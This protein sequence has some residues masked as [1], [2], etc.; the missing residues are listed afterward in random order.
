M[1]TPLQ[2]FLPGKSQ[3]Q[4]R[5]VGYINGVAKELDTT[6]WL[7]NNRIS[8][9]SHYPGESVVKNRPANAGDTGLIPVLGRCS[10]EGN[11]TVHRILLPEESH[12]Q[13]SLVGY[14]S[15]GCTRVGHDWETKNNDCIG[16]LYLIYSWYILILCLE[17]SLYTMLGLF[18]LTK[19]RI[20]IRNELK[21]IC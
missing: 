17:Y 7:N 2:Y 12:G 21:F 15:W 4:R 9:G 10:V 13:W 1:A 14:N 11:D 8:T 6:E 5:L 20:K 18:F 3:R 19:I 16:S